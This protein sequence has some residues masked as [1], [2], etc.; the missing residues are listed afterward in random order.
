M[1]YTY[2]CKEHGEFE[3]SMSIKEHTKTQLCPTCRKLCTQVIVHSPNITFK[4]GDWASK[5][6]AVVD[7]VNRDWKGKGQGYC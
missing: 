3:A 1:I 5:K 2:K 7:P 6:P 4:G